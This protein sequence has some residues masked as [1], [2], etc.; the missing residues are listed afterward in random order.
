MVYYKAT[1]NITLFF[2]FFIRV[3]R[4][5]KSPPIICEVI[6]NV[7][8]LFSDKESCIIS[9]QSSYMGTLLKCNENHVTVY[10]SGWFAVFFYLS[11]HWLFGW[12][13][14]PGEESQGDLPGGEDHTE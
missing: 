11:V 5:P 12:C 13:F 1:F 3:K 10:L 4:T 7:S 2:F 8:R 9:T 14:F 6:C